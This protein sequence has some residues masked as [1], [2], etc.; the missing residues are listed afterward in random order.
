M[1]WPYFPCES[2][3]GPR[4]FS[5]CADRMW[6]ILQKGGKRVFVRVPE[7]MVRMLQTY[8]RKPAEPIFQQP[9]KKTAFTKTPACFQ[10]AVRKLNLAPKDGD[11]LYAVT[12][13][14]MR[15][16]FASWLAQ[17]GKVMLMGLQK[18][19]RHKNI[20]MTMRYAYLF[21]GCVVILHMT[22][23]RHGLGQEN[24]KLLIIGDML[25]AWESRHFDSEVWMHPD[26]IYS[27][28]TARS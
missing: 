17:S 21:L 12:L 18:L 13:H 8:K 23:W 26:A 7:D 2:V 5:S 3:S 15:H 20:T 16:T 6:Y 22:I 1:T 14:T 25:A 19:M 11:S 9:R 10:T 4:K 28:K 24:E 27:S